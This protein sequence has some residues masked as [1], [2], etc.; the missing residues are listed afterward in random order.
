VGGAGHSPAC[1]HSS[2]SPPRRCAWVRDQ[3]YEDGAA[4]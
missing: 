4:P 3:S 1:S 2:A